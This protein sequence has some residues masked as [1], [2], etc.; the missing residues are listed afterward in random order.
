MAA[1]ERT[2]RYETAI[3]TFVGF[4]ALIVSAYTAYEQHLQVRAQVWPILEITMGNSPLAVHLANKGVGPAIV[5]D[6]VV[7]LDGAPVKDW[8]E[9]LVKLLGPGEH[10]L[11]WN[12]IN[13][14]IIAAG[15]TFDLVRPKADDGSD[16]HVGKGQTLA[17]AI[18]E[19][20]SRYT[21]ELCYCSTLDECWRLVTKATEP[22]VTTPTRRCPPLS[23]A[24][25]HD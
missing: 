25:F 24:S 11:Y 9:L 3:A 16:L 2:L 7:R 15:E 13:A 14:R 22:P 8:D 10:A 12:S 19:A 6:A 21:I 17:N 1:S 20:R 23:A 18:W 5:R 4:L